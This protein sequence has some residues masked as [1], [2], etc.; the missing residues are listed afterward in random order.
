[1]R[2]DPDMVEEVAEQFYEAAVNRK[3]HN[4][5]IW[6]IYSAADQVKLDYVRIL[7]RES[8]DIYSAI[9]QT[10]WQRIQNLADQTLDQEKRL[11]LSDIL[12]S[13]DEA[14]L[15]ALNR[16]LIGEGGELLEG[17]FKANPNGVKAWEV[18]RRNG[19]DILRTEIDALGSLSNL[20]SNPKL[21]S[22]LPGKSTEE[23]EDL[24]GKMKGWGDGT[25][26]VSYKQVADKVNELIEELPATT[27]NFDKYLGTAGF[28]NGNV[29]TNR[30][31]WVQLERMLEPA[32][33]SFIKSADEIIFENLISGTPFGNSVSDIF[34]RK[35]SQIVEVET[36]AGL[37]FFED[38]PGSNF[39]TQSAN[40]LT[41]V[42]S[43]SDYKVILNPEK[44]TTLSNADKLKVVNAWK[45][46]PGNIFSNDIIV[47]LFE[48]YWDEVIT[49]PDHLENLL[50]TRNDWFDDIFKN[51][52]Q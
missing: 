10:K 46:H 34:I 8:D 7:A 3:F 6:T 20:L 39:A 29:Y 18:L 22:K 17:F 16:D 36:K 49:G 23:I 12:K 4:N 43:V 14:T 30:H 1:M 25:S 13:M 31:S 51:N 48:D 40:S 32:N 42:S 24:L 41:R 52:I 47:G 2:I 21:A 15:D 35:G 27:T 28:G 38:I 9:R 37:Q 26:G 50:K 19:R 11:I 5:Q 44:V 33:K 45:N